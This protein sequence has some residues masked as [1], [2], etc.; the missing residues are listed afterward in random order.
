[1]KKFLSVSLASATL[2][3]V[4]A[5]G[6]LASAEEVG[7]MESTYSIGFGTHIEWPDLGDDELTLQYVPKT[8]NF[9][10][11]N[12]LDGGTFEERSNVNLYAVVRDDRPEEETTNVWSLTASASEMADVSEV[13]AA[14]VKT[15]FIS[16]AGEAKSYSGDFEQPVEGSNI[17]APLASS[18]SV[19]EDIT[20]YTNG[21]SAE[22]MSK[23]ETQDAGWAAAGFKDIQM[24]VPRRAVEFGAQYKGTITWSLNDTI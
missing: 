14:N 11:D 1:M 22:I 13:G 17:D 10:Q 15:A 19:S 12:D 2:L 3:S 5:G 16:M 18:P 23:S 4:I 7:S 24:T 8:L 20:L 6:A 9:G 21:T